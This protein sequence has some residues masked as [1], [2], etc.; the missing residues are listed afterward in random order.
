MR[1]LTTS[2]L[3]LV[4]LANLAYA[5]EAAKSDAAK[6]QQVPPDLDKIMAYY[7]GNWTVNAT[8]GEAVLTGRARFQMPRGSHSI[9][10]TLMMEGDGQEM[11]LSLVAGW[12]SSTG[13]VTEQGVGTDGSVY[14]LPWKKVSEDA[15]EGDLTGTV[16]GQKMSEKLRLE[17]KARGEYVVVIT[18]R[19][20]GDESLPNLTIVFQR[21]AREKVMPQRAKVRR[22][23]KKKQ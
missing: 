14:Q 10:G 19:K 8:A 4:L 2:I 7:V 17:R 3:T 21:A 20:V 13:W 9:L 6:S 12:D 23:I 1:R 18:D 16:N 15:Q 22:E 11:Q 5:Q